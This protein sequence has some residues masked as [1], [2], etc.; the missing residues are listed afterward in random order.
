MARKLP[1]TNNPPFEV[2]QPEPNVSHFDPGG[3]QLSLYPDPPTLDPTQEP[4]E[5]IDDAD[6]QEESPNP[7][8]PHKPE[9]AIQTP[10]SPE[11]QNTI[12]GRTRPQTGSRTSHTTML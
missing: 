9:D 2:K 3:K 8:T 6:T 7:N 5:V 12:F 10:E 1:T 4:Q 11:N